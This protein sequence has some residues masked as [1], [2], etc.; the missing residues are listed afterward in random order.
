MKLVFEFTKT[1]ALIYISH[2]DL[3][4][5]FLRVLRMSGLRPSYSHGFNP[6]PKMSFVLPLSL[7]LHSICELLEFEIE[8]MDNN[9]MKLNTAYITASVAVA[10]ERL[11]EGVSITS[12]SIKPDSVQKPLASYAAACTYEI[13]CEGVKDAPGKLTVFFSQK[14][15]IAQKADKKTKTLVDKDIREDMLGY[16][17]VKDMP[18]RMLAE[19]SLSASPG[20]TL[21]PLVFFNA[22]CEASGLERDKLS[23]VI[24][25]TAILDNEG[26]PLRERCFG[27]KDGW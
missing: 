7:G 1:G 26:R 8:S 20:R 18:G 11:P 12:W 5:L 15:I 2:L 21:G 4:R 27:K 23:P 10:N 14:I 13:M 24:T 19:A 25:R 9:D 17:V 22:F 6:H 3:T 16:R